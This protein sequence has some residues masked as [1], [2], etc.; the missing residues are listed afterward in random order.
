[1]NQKTICLALGVLGLACGYLVRVS[2]KKGSSDQAEISPALNGASSQ[3]RKY[4]NN[5]QAEA[6]AVKKAIAAAME[7]LP[8]STDTRESILQADQFTEYGRI[9]LWMI[10]ASAADIAAYWTA[11]EARENQNRAVTDLVFIN[12]TRLDPDAATAATRGTKYDEF[13]W[14]AWACHDPQNALQKAIASHPDRIP[15]VTWGIGEFH[16]EWLLKNMD[17]IPE[18]G[19]ANALQALTKWDDVRDPLSILTFLK[20]NDA[21]HQAGGIFKSLVRQDPWQAYD[22]MIKNGSNNSTFYNGDAVTQQFLDTLTQAHP[23]MLENFASQAE[24]LTLKHSLQMKFF[25]TLLDENPQEALKQAKENSNPLTRYQQLEKIALRSAANDPDQ[26]MELMKELLKYDL[27]TNLS[28]YE[29]GASW[30]PVQLNEGLL[31]RF[32]QTDPEGLMN[33]VQKNGHNNIHTISRAWLQ[34]D[35]PAF[36]NWLGEQKDPFEGA[37]LSTMIDHWE[38]LQKYDEAAQFILQHEKKNEENAEV[39]LSDVI[40]RWSK[41]NPEQARQW[42]DSAPLAEH[43]KTFLRTELSEAE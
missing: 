14:W 40:S 26:A 27:K 39:Y 11:H 28:L 34:Q 21:Q 4:R 31:L 24:S 36:R 17:Q 33:A 32:I 25:E 7:S 6:P 12:W 9:A 19:K 37:G 2:G 16:S 20:D 8:K 15:N 42:I 1:M 18:S 30:S 10:D 22:W 35:E 29:N 13:S 23:E 3:T 43:K 38:N 5:F 41:E